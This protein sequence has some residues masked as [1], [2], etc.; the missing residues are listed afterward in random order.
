M[1]APPRGLSRRAYLHCFWRL[2]PDDS[3]SV[4]A[5]VALHAPIVRRFTDLPAPRGLG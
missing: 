5:V 3:L 2:D 4:L 1:A